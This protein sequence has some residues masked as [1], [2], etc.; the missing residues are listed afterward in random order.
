M[1]S[2]FVVVLLVVLHCGASVGE[3]TRSALRWLP[4]LSSAGAGEFCAGEFSPNGPTV[5]VE[6][7]QASKHAVARG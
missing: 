5:L 1:E 7:L 4:T 2:Q 3:Q 6:W